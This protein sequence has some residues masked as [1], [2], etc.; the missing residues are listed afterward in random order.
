M[1]RT[2]K[3]QRSQSPTSNTIAFRASEELLALID[4]A[5][6]NLGVTRGEFVRAVVTTHFES[7]PAAIV[8]DLAN[9]ADEL[10]KVLAKTSLLHRNQARLLV[11]L[12]TTV[13]K[14]PLPEAKELARVT[15]LS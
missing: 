13:A 8:S 6:N 5:A 9:L 11:T 4:D 15:L 2:Q 1:P 14:L 7:Q 10:A 12:L 3:K